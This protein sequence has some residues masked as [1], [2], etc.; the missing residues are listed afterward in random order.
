M[1]RG[2]GAIFTTGAALVGATVVVANPVSA[3]PSDVRVPAVKLSADSSTSSVA[4]DRAL[5]EAIARDHAETNPTAPLKRLFAGVVTDVTMLGGKA[6]DR[7]FWAEVPGEATPVPTPPSPAAPPTAVAELLSGKPTDIAP[8]RN[9][10]PVLAEDRALQHAV[11]SVAD[12][13]GYVSVHVVE[14][15]VA[16][17]GIAAAGPK[18]IAD[19][20]AA[21][22]DGDVDNAIATALRVVAVPLGPPSTIVKAIRTV[23]RQRLT[24]LADLLR[25]PVQ[26]RPKAGPITHTA[27]TDSLASLRRALGHRRGL[28]VTGKPESSSKPA[29]SLA[30]A[31][32]EPDA[33]PP[34]VNGATD[35]SHG[36]KAVPSTKAVPSE[37]PQGVETTVNQVRTSLDRFTE[38]LR[39]ALTPHQPHQRTGTT[40][41]AAS[42]PDAP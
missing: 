37:G 30:P 4:L 9:V 23:V 18:H 15:T 29:A 2:I 41:A 6:V 12:Y 32:T 38:T 31:G 13:V 36:N 1:R 16:A 19:T 5:L 10:P 33:K 24:E 7:A 20:L 34:T 26:S 17:A 27:V 28:A 21:L 35:L 42:A 39:K 8:A 3:P 14:E 11:T 25:R 22:T 40:P